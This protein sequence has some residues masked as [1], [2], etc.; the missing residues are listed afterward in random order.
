MLAIGLSSTRHVN[1]DTL[2]ADVP[3]FADISRSFRSPR[4]RLT[5]SYSLAYCAMSFSAN[6]RFRSTIFCIS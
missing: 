6:S 1:A 3:D 4:P 2:S 5:V